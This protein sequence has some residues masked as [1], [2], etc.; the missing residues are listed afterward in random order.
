MT[1]I[2]ITMRNLQQL[3][4]IKANEQLPT[5]DKVLEML[6]KEYFK[7]HTIETI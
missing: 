4:L 5:H 1:T 6:I 2:R 3:N 7:T